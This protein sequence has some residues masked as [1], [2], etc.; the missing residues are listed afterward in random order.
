MKEV[1]I[2]QLAKQLNL[3]VSTVSRALNDSY[4]I[5]AETKKRVRE[6]ARQ[7]NYQPNPNASNLRKRSSKTIAV[8]IPEIANNFF[9]LVI[10]GIEEI[11]QENGFHVLI[12]ITHENNAKEAAY[13][14]LLRNGRVDGVLISMSGEVNDISHINALI[15]S[16]IPL[17]FFDRICEEAKTPKITT[18]DYQSAYDGTLHLINK[19]CTQIAYLGISQTHSIGK[20]RLTGYMD[21]MRNKGLEIKPDFIIKQ[22]NYPQIEQLLSSPNRPQAIFAAVEQAALQC[23]E[24]AAKLDLNIPNDLKVISFSNLRTAP[25]LNPSLTTITQPAFDIGR[26]AAKALFGLLKKKFSCMENEII[27]LTSTLVERESTAG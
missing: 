9:T 12:Y 24:V 21:A 20:A 23:Y 18:N 17:V 15:D 3:A 25:L 4:E 6:L 19:G 8:I 10:D 16:S 1:N 5:G 13:C 27:T 14:N 22:S 7:L 2:K 11:A 26:E